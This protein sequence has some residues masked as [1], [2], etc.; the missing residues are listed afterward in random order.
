MHV[1]CKAVA[2]L[3]IVGFPLSVLARE[4]SPPGDARTFTY[5]KTKQGELKIH[6]HFPADWQKGDKRPAVVF[7]FGG[8][9]NSGTV[10][11]FV[12]Q[13]E[14]LARRGMLAARADYRVRSR[15]QVAP[16]KCVEDAKSAVRW[17]RQ[18]ARK[19]GVDPDRIVASGG[20]AGGH[21]AA[22]TG[23]TPG[24]ETEGEN[25]SV[26][27]KPNAMVLF[28]PVL[29]L[30]RSDRLLQRLGGNEELAKL[31][32]P[33]L[34]LKKD[35]PPALIL[36]GTKDRLLA[37]AEEFIARSKQAGNRAEMYL[38]EG[39]G[40]GFFNRSPWR[41]RTLRRADEFLSSLGY[42]KGKPRIEI[43]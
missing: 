25:L 14:Y 30:S 21:V 9:W 36:F 26:S 8:G 7:F 18:N 22:C 13:A 12:P 28:N 24:P 3:L 1:F 40:H 43:P 35:T 39:Q 2:V 17:I 42:L 38:A 10:R 29:N 34:H 33:T 15:H 6:L 32:S 41:E 5:K 31:I 37:H 27:S 16:D 23:C 19:L 20:S 4:Q 11:Q